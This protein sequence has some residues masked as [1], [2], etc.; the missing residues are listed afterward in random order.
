LR[1]EKMLIKIQYDRNAY[2]IIDVPESVMNYYME[3]RV[4]FYNRIYEWLKENVASYYSDNGYC[5]TSE[6][7]KWLN[8]DFIKDAN[9]IA[10]VIEFERIDTDTDDLPVINF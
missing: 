1:G 4:E 3:N 6:V 9:E 2:D 5:H 8:A 7:V 10:K